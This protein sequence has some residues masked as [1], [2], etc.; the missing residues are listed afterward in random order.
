[1]VYNATHSKNMYSLRWNLQRDIEFPLHVCTWF[2]N[3]IAGICFSE[4]KTGKKHQLADLKI[5]VKTM[6]LHRAGSKQ[7]F[8]SLLVF[9]VSDWLSYQ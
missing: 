5:N 4:T 9:F 8:K 2:T 6:T 7:F 3:I 1:M